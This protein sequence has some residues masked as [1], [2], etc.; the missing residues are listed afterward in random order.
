LGADFTIFFSSLGDPTQAQ[1]N[2]IGVG[3][4]GSVLV[5][6]GTDS[7]D[8]S[9]PLSLLG[10]DDGIAMFGLAVGIP[11][12][13]DQFNPTDFIFDDYSLGGPTSAV[14]VPEPTSLLLLG[15]GLAGLVALRRKFR[16]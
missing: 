3:F 6:F 16:V 8:L 1:V 15:S 10:N 2:Q 14:A 5:S 12:L 9:V 7:F 4:Q 13:S 11:T